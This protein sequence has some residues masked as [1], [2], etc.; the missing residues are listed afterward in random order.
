M[1]NEKNQPK[2]AEKAKKRL[3]NAKSSKSRK[4]GITGKNE[5]FQPR[6]ETR[7][8][9]RDLTKTQRPEGAAGG[10]N[11]KVAK[12]AGSQVRDQERPGILRAR[13]PEPG[14]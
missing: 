3:K 5:E 4:N 2:W 12:G 6:T 14:S 9:S 7:M 8:N 10:C 11:A 1:K 13:G